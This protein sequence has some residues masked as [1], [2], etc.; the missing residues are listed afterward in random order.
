[1]HCIEG[2]YRD[3]KR[4]EHPCEDGRHEFDQSYAGYEFSHCLAV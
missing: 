1:M 4:L 3:W 2:P